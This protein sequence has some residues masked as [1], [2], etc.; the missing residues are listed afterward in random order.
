VKKTHP[1]PHQKAATNLQHS[2][3]E[4]LDSAVDGMISNHCLSA[5]GKS[6]HGPQPS[7]TRFSSER[8]M[9]PKGKRRKTKLTWPGKLICTGLSPEFWEGEKLILAW[10]WDKR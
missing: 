9:R 5:W 8:K 6:R 2:T 10:E 4:P 7:A 3:L 1:T